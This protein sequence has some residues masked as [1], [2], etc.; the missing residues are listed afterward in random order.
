MS[1]SSKA[2]NILKV[3]IAITFYEHKHIE[4]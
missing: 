1:L 4:L 2:L 3:K